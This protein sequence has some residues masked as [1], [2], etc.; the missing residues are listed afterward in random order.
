MVQG[1][2]SV[3][4]LGHGLIESVRVFAEGHP[5]DFFTGLL[6]RRLGQ[7]LRQRRMRRFLRRR[8][9]SKREG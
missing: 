9:Q 8:A 3:E 1:V 4:D 2:I 5:R 6:P 7:W